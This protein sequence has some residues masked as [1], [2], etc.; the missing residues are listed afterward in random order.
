MQINAR[1]PIFAELKARVGDGTGDV[2]ET[3]RDIAAL[4]F[5]TA[6][7][8]SGFTIED[9]KDFAT[10]A[11]RLVAKGLALPSLELLPEMELPP[12]AAEE[13][14]EGDAPDAPPAFE[15]EL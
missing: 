13:E 7:L 15:E 3:T 4:L 2:D 8:S 10:R 5:D 12:P 14:E 1:H 11:Y 9:P 6:L